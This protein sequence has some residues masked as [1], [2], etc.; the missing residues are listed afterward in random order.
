VNQT[1]NY[2]RYSFVASE[3]ER[4]GLAKVLI[5]ITTEAAFNYVSKDDANC[6]A[7]NKN[8]Y[9]NQI[10]IYNGLKYNLN[11]NKFI[12]LAFDL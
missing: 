5:T 4:D 3:V 1:G 6:H 7:V 9:L 2:N 12:P 8:D 10:F 11:K